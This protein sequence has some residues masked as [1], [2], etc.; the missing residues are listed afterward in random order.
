MLTVWVFT[1]GEQVQ[2]VES[3][4]IPGRANKAQFT[5]VSLR[6]INEED[7]VPEIGLPSVRGVDD[8]E[9]KYRP[10]LLNLLMIKFRS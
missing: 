6:H 8:D 2:R 9:G 1:F 4:L 10:L 7:V 3:S 5:D